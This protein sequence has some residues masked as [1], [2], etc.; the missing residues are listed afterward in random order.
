VSRYDELRSAAAT[1]EDLMLFLAPELMLYAEELK[2][3]WEADTWYDL[4]RHASNPGSTNMRNARQR[5][6]EAI[7]ALRPLFGDKR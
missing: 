6:D 1:G 2:A 4:M 7:E 5:R 3:L